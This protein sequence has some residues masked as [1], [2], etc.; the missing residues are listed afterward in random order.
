[1]RAIQQNKNGL[2]SL[3]SAY[4]RLLAAEARRLATP[5]GLD[6]SVYIVNPDCNPGVGLKYVSI[7]L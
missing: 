1:L 7:A 4:L 3:F 5:Q 2:F 6:F